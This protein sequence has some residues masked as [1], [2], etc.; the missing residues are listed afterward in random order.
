MKQQ[1]RTRR[2]L[3]ADEVR[4]V[5]AEAIEDYRD[6]REAGADWVQGLYDPAPAELLREKLAERGGWESLA[7]RGAMVGVYEALFPGFAKRNMSQ[8]TWTGVQ[9]FWREAGNAEPTQYWLRGF[10]DGAAESAAE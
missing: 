9:E 8:E 1:A 10:V 5:V 2:E 3:E 6:G 7:E 4:E